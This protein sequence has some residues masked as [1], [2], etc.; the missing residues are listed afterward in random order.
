VA[1]FVDAAGRDRGVE[2]HRRD[3]GYSFHD[4]RADNR[5]VGRNLFGPGGHKKK[6]LRALNHAI[7]HITAYGGLYAHDGTVRHGR[8]LLD[9]PSDRYVLFDDS[10][11]MPK[12]AVHL[13]VTAPQGMQTLPDT[14]A[15]VVAKT[16]RRFGGDDVLPATG[17]ITFINRST[18]SPHF[19]VLQHVKEGTTRKQVI[20]SF[21]SDT[22]PTFVLRG[23]QESDVLT[24]DRRLNLHLHLPPGQYAQMCFFPDPKTGDPHA[25]MG[26][27]RMVHLR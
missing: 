5:V 24:T 11:Q 4:F 10:G 9:T 2:I 27:V 6:G 18:E 16:N 1:H 14:S 21:S 22:R 26:M 25:F 23:D 20:R 3:P 13:T 12:R 7:N 8:L 15:R 19:L 17:N